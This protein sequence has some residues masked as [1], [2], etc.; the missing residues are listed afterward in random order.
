MQIFCKYNKFKK[1]LLFLMAFFYLLFF[2]GVS[3][4]LPFIPSWNVYVQF[5][6]WGLTVKFAEQAVALGGMLPYLE[7]QSDRVSLG[8]LCLG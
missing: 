2:G 8:R 7:F 4:G 1:K 3:K 5:C 6:L